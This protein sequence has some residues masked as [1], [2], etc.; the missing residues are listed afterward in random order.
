MGPPL[1]LTEIDFEAVE[2]CTD[3]RQLKRMLLLLQQDGGYYREL[4]QAAEDRLLQLTGRPYKAAPATEAD[5]QQVAAD[6]LAWERSMQQQQQP[7]EDTP[8]LEPIRQQRTAAAPQHT[9]HAHVESNLS[10]NSSNSNSSSSSNSG[11]SSSKPVVRAAA[12]AEEQSSKD[13]PPPAAAAAES[14]PSQPHCGSK[15]AAAAS[16]AA[17]AAAAEKS[18][19]GRVRIPVSVVEDSEDEFALSPLAAPRQQTS[20]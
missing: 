12:Q 11:S 3:P 16:T 6:L 10:T 4:M 9:K 19:C 14:T 5:R 8:E 20:G 7:A 17:T 15:T 13:C 18:A 2:Q 1:S